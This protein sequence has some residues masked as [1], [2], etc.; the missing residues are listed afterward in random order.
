M[1]TWIAGLLV[2]LVS[3]TVSAGGTP[4]PSDSK[5]DCWHQPPTDS[6]RYELI[7]KFGHNFSTQSLSSVFSFLE[8]QGLHGCQQ[9]LGPSGACLVTYST[10]KYP[11]TP[12]RLA[13]ELLEK[14]RLRTH[15]LGIVKSQ[16]NLFEYVVPNAPLHFA[17]SPRTRPSPSTL[18]LSFQSELH[19]L[20][21]AVAWQQVPLDS[22][23]VTA[24][25]DTGVEGDHPDLRENV[26]PN[27]IDFTCKSS[28]NCGNDTSD[29]DGHGTH[30]AGI[31]AGVGHDKGRGTVGIAWNTNIL[32]L[33]I[34]TVTVASDFQGAEA[35]EAAITREVDVINASWDEPCELTRV[36]EAMANA[37]DRGILFV[38]AAGNKG[39]DLEGAG[40]NT[41]PAVYG[42]TRAMVVMAVDA[43]DNLESISNWGQNTVDIAAPS[44][45]FAP[46]KMSGE[47]DSTIVGCYDEIAPCTSA[48]TAYV[49]GAAALLKSA[50]PHW[51]A[52]WLKTQ[53]IESGHAEPALLL[54]SKHGVSLRLDQALQGPIQLTSPLAQTSWKV[55]DPQTVQWTN[56]YP[57]SLCTQVTI[58]LTT[59]AFQDKVLVTGVA[60]NGA[61]TVNLTGVAPS[62][63]ASLRVTCAPADLYSQSGEFRLTQ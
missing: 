32:P 49:S 10:S 57:S 1:R 4:R 54:K 50:H 38:V 11:E 31:I 45:A 12:D 2:L 23:I 41:Y 3:N 43:Q 58:S 13:Q 47:C 6:S 28:S 60:N 14:W 16:G 53:L 20:G 62:D 25:I 51:S 17:V 33:R 15:E 30:M 40:K 52:E 35:I 34:T 59:E 55:S 42:G 27:G 37:Q 22:S 24:V 19:R 5:P 39:L 63:H 8:H 9:T 7:I 56:R 21:A 36:K 29:R 26:Q 46:M 18:T 48:A 44:M 61:A